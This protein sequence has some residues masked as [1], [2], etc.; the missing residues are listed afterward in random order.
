MIFVTL[1]AVILNVPVPIM[2]SKPLTTDD[3]ATVRAAVYN[4]ELATA[5]S[6]GGLGAIVVVPKDVIAVYTKNPAETLALLLKI[7]EGG[8]PSDSV[9]AACYSLDLRDGPGA[10]VPCALMFKSEAWDKADKDWKT[11]PR[12]HWV[13]QLK[14]KAP[15]E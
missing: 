12:E 3:V 14:A 1:L 13:T 8:N 7:A 11:T 10:G 2:K 4:D 15:K 5:S 6:D 9:K